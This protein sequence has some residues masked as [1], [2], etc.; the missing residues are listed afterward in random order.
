MSQLA[1][2]VHVVAI[3]L[4]FKR[5]SEAL[6]E[7]Q[8]RSSR[9][10]HVELDSLDVSDFLSFDRNVE[11]HPRLEGGPLVG[12]FRVLDRLV[13]RL[14]SADYFVLLGER[15]GARVGAQKLLDFVWQ[16]NQKHVFIFKHLH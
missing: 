9:E 4:D 8:N 1:S 10:R 5:E 16:F 15:E 2:D 12:P 14:E 13:A 6:V 7:R 11:R 3:L